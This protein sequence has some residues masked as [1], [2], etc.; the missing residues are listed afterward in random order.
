METETETPETTETETEVV[1]T[2]ETIEVPE[3]A[4]KPDAVKAAIKAERDAAKA[5]RKEAD[6]LRAKL[7]EHEDRNKTDEQKLTERAE[8][9]DAAEAKAL[10]Y[11]VAAAK[12]ID[13]RLAL[14]LTGSTREELEADADTLK[15]LVKSETPSPDLDGGA[16][17]TAPK[18]KVDPEKAHG[19]FLADLLGGQSQ[20]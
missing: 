2:E 1:E 18:P 3:G 5:A 8:R 9:A 6:D 14:R 20:S 4:D 12:G 7:R 13:L 19:Q 11:E 15:G 17:K 10:R 16:R